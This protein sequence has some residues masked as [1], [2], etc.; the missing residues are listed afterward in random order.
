MFDKYIWEM[1]SYYL[2]PHDVIV[3]EKIEFERVITSTLATNYKN[4][5][6]DIILAERSEGYVATPLDIRIDKYRTSQ[7]KMESMLSNKIESINEDRMFQSNLQITES[8][9]REK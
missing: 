5:Y 1:N 9:I 8:L 6:K 2:N 3:R 7:F 4:I